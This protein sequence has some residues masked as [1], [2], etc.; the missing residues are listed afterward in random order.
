[1][2]IKWEAG[3]WSSS[4]LVSGKLCAFLGQS[5]SSLATGQ[6]GMERNPLHW[7]GPQISGRPFRMAQLQPKQE[8]KQHLVNAQSHK[9]WRGVVSEHGVSQHFATQVRWTHSWVWSG[10]Q[11]KAEYFSH[12]PF[13]INQMCQTCRC[14]RWELRIPPRPRNIHSQP[15]GHDPSGKPQSP[16][17]F[18]LWLRYDS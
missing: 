3:R 12:C 14:H 8:L 5:L 7:L 17:T 15:V 9:E 10:S 4:L 6:E 2:T 11:L 13:Q 1:M 16:K 18:T